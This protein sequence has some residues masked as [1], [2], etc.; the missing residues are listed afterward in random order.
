MTR[1]TRALALSALLALCGCFAP[2]GDS[3]LAIP[4]SHENWTGLVSEVRAF[5]QRM[6]FEETKNFRTFSS[7]TKEFPFC[8]YVSRS[9]LP[10]SYEDP[11]ITWLNAHT[12]EEC[13]AYGEDA[14]VTF[15]T[16]EAVAERETP[17]TLSMLVAPLNRFLYLVVHEDCHDQFGLPYGIE[18]PLCNVIAFKAI[19]AFGEAR[20]KSMA[21]RRAIQRLACDGAAHSRVTVA[22]YERL[23][24]LYEQHE[25]ARLS[26]TALLK[27]R[28]R[29]FRTAEKQL[30]WP[31]GS[32]NNVWIANAMTY[33]RHYAL[34]E[35]VF[36]ALDRDL[37]RTV[38]FFK[39]VD[40]VKPSPA[41]VVAK[42]RLA[43]DSSVEFV[44]AYEAAVVGT[45]ERELAA[46]ISAKDVRR[47]REGGNP[48][49][50]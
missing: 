10:Y 42:H 25:Q 31:R 5:A 37:A 24:A 49:A 21:E 38:A 1:L 17:V 23:A 18:E 26:Q 32:M 13:H 7:E 14:D 4:R 47:S 33:S 50:L 36:E 11:A 29:I 12:K 34:I 15:G 45:I 40:A 35:R 6:G 44:R 20:F 16:T 19:A 43:T 48:G 2:R 30:S 3:E 28:A 41:E 46:V 27:E 39:Q 9:Y 8:G 22:S